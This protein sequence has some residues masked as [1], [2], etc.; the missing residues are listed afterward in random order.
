MDDVTAMIQDIK[1]EVK[2][3]RLN[4]NAWE[5]NF[6][7]S[8]SKLAYEKKELSERQDEILLKLWKKSRESDAD[9]GD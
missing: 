7:Q 6:L 5:E 9:Q 2:E 8:I 4:L 1:R 3:G